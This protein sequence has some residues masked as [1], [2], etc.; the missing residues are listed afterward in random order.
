MV[1]DESGLTVSVQQSMRDSDRYS[2]DNRGFRMD[3]TA[4]SMSNTAPNLRATP[5][6]DL[7]YHIGLPGKHPMQF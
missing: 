2:W 4:C 7:L 5:I 6:A 1:A 3:P